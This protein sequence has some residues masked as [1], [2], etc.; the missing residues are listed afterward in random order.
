MCNNQVLGVSRTEVSS[1]PRRTCH[2]RN[3]SKRGG[4]GGRTPASTGPG[5]GLGTTTTPLAGDRS[6]ED[7][8]NPAGGPRPHL[9]TII[10][11]SMEAPDLGEGVCQQRRAEGSIMDQI[12]WDSKTTDPEV[13][14]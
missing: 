2:S 11:P 5:G 6:Q 14:I 8:N 13:G 12:K 4:A 3:L 10:I 7:N 9:A 1:S